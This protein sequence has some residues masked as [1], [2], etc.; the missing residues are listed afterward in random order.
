MKKAAIN[1][2][3][4]GKSLNNSH[5]PAM[6]K[7]KMIMVRGANS[8]RMILFDTTLAVSVGD[9]VGWLMIVLSAETG[10]DPKREPRSTYP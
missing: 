4:T 6:T 5:N 9:S 1:T 10:K 2:S 8:N 7:T 3:S